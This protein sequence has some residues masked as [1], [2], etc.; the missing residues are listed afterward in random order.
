MSHSVSLFWILQQAFHGR[1]GRAYL[2][3]Q[4]YVLIPSSAMQTIWIPVHMYGFL[5]HSFFAA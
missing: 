1:F 4:A 3:N 5:A 2:V